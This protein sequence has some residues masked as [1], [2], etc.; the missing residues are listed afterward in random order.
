MA[1]AAATETQAGY[2]SGALT[3]DTMLAAVPGIKDLANINGNGN[4]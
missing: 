3:I 1:A 2:T 4:L